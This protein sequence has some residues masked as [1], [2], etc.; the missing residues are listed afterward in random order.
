MYP[1]LPSASGMIPNARVLEADW[2]P[3]EIVHCNPEQNRLRDA[4]VPVVDGEPPEHVL[5][6]G[7]SGAE[8]AHLT[9]P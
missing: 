4:L 1:V 7:A 6:T 9:R 2:V 8:R 5:I 3:R